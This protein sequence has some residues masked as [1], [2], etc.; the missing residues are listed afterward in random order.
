PCEHCRHSHY[1][2]GR[3]AKVR[4][5]DEL[6]H[7]K[8]DPGPNHPSDVYVGAEYTAGAAGGDGQRHRQN[9][10]QGK[11]N[12]GPADVITGHS[13]LNPTISGGNSFWD[14]KCQQPHQKPS[15][16]WLDVI[17]YL[18]TSKQIP[19]AI[20][21]GRFNRSNNPGG[22]SLPRVTNERNRLSKMDGLR[23]KKYRRPTD[24]QSVYCVSD[25]RC[26][27]CVDKSF[28]LKGHAGIENLHGENGHSEGR[29]KDRRQSRSHSRKDE[30]SPVPVRQM[31]DISEDR[32]NAHANLCGR[33][34]ATQTRL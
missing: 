28:G 4:A 13:L 7:D 12:K 10:G 24:K 11:K 1:G 22:N 32:T 17:R 3:R 29:S 27:D 25:D 20:K 18:E 23:K 6:V 16:R 8:S 30:S 31:H 15:Y 19:N 5:R 14:D 21:Y 26:D 9:L 2:E 33:S 34:F